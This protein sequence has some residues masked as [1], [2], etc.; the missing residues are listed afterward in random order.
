MSIDLTIDAGLTSG[1]GGNPL[2]LELKSLL[3]ENED[4]YIDVKFYEQTI[5]G[6]EAV[7][8]KLYSY[9]LMNGMAHILKDGTIVQAKD[10]ED[11]LL[12]DTIQKQ[13]R[14]ENDNLMFNQ[15]GSPV[16]ED[17]EVPTALLNQF[18]RWV[19]AMKPYVWDAQGAL[20][21]GIKQF[22]KLV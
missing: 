6:G 17:V 16:L 20:K 22:Y 12:F 19:T 9:R 3:V 18:T 7:K 2:Q 13:S 1:L 8:K 4:K 15:D 11:N 21:D 10:S 14:D 5:V